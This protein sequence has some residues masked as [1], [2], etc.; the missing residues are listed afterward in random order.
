MLAA[1][2]GAVERRVPKVP[3][4]ISGVE[5]GADLTSLLPEEYAMLGLPVTEAEAFRRLA[6][7]QALQ[8]ARSGKEKMTKGPLVLLVDESASMRA[9]GDETRNIYAKSV[10]TALT[11]LAWEGGRPVV[12]VAYATATRV[13]TLLP[14]DVLGLVESQSRFLDG[15]TDI[16]AALHAGLRAVKTLEQQGFKGADLVLISDGRTDHDSRPQMPGA[17]DAVTAA[18][19]R[20]W[21]VA[22][23]VEFEQLIVDHSAKY[24]HL[25]KDD[26]KSPAGAAKLA[27]AAAP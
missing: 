27:G 5:R 18:R 6:E 20:L 9:Q 25:T 26:M 21:S 16:P 19:V 17:L 23:E 12:W 22:I 14:G 15:G 10:A 13:R 11:R 4:E 2:R 3:D 1:L 24:I 7:R 8:Y